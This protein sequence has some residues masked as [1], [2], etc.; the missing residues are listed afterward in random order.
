MKL[1][2]FNL[3]EAKQGKPVC[4]RDG[5]PVRLLCFDYKDRDYSIVGL[6]SYGEYESVATFTEEGKWSKD[7]TYSSCD[8][9]MAPVKH[10]GWINIYPNNCSSCQIYPTEK[11]AKSC[12]NDAAIATTKIEWE[13]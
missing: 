13:E 1:K 7:R 3:E 11:D 12:A 2:P 5:H 4:T 10:E 6:I 8:L 9:F